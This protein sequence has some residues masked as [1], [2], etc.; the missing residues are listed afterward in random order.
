ML[1][2]HII[3]IATSAALLSSTGAIA[4]TSPAST[5]S[6]ARSA[7]GDLALS[8]STNGIVPASVFLIAMFAAVLLFGLDGDS[9]S[10]VS[11]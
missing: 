11:P 3:A 2:K 7:K 8:G 1:K 5:L 9:G 4:Q 10:P 6:V